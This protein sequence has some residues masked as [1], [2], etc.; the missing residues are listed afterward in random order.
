MYPSN[1]RKPTDHQPKTERTRSAK[2]GTH[3]QRA[4]AAYR[5]RSVLTADGYLAAAGASRALIAKYRSAFGRAAAKAYR[6]AT[7]SEPT[8]SGW[9][10]AHGRLLPVFAYQDRALLDSVL[11]GYVVKY[12]TRARLTDL[13]G[14]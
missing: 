5:N 13:I 8:Q 4:I 9:A 1:W 6:A 7:S 10:I 3:V 12:P 11:A 2:P 14:A